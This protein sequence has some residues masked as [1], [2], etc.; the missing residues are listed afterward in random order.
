MDA[1]S[2]DRL[3]RRV[4]HATSRRRFLRSIAVG[5][6][7]LG[8]FRADQGIKA[9]DD[10]SGGVALGEPCSD[11]RECA[12]YPACGAP[13]SV[14]CMD[15]GI[16]EEGPLNCCLQDGAECPSGSDAFC[17]GSLICVGGGGDG[18][19]AGH[20]R[21]SGDTEAL[22]QQSCASG[23]RCSQQGGASQCTRAFRNQAMEIFCCRD[24]DGMCASDNDCCRT[25]TCN[26]GYCGSL[27]AGE[28][29]T[30][31][32]DLDLRESPPAHPLLGYQE[33][34]EPLLIAPPGSTVTLT[35]DGEV[36]GRIGVEYQGIV[37][38]VLEASLTDQASEPL[39][40]MSGSDDP[41]AS[42]SSKPQEADCTLVELRPGYPGYRGFVTGLYGAGEATCLEDLRQLYPW[43]DQDKEDA[44]NFAAAARLDLAGVPSTWVWENWLAIEETR[45]FPLTCYLSAYQLIVQGE[46]F[47]RASVA[48]NDVRLLVGNIDSRELLGRVA[49]T[50]NVPLWSLENV[51][52]T[53]YHLRAMAW[54]TSGKRQINAEELLMA[55]DSI[56]LMFNTPGQGGPVISSLVQTQGGYVPVPGRACPDDQVFLA[57]ITISAD[58][59]A[60]PAFGLLGN[61]DVNTG[62]WRAEIAQ[63]ST[64]PLRRF[65]RENTP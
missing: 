22:P 26:S 19:G 59:W 27:L 12:L 29:R 61:F 6:G 3:A 62:L 57:R 16:A 33:D 10:S 8:G 39:L 45:G 24:T 32:R 2:F 1:V 51:F 58:Q 65:L 25:M 43:F 5:V 46:P 52:P 37:G 36:Y 56:A 54:A 31:I 55:F 50:A 41:D 30:A 4:A 11:S 60:Y 14:A 42:G 44:E 20:C 28:L 63:G 40:A 13:Q 17:C 23:E 53:D 38:W 47:T 21:F 34:E 15:N 35:A 48:E 49:A 18:C 9:Q 64:Q 7:A